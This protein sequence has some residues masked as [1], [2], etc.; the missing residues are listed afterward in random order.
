M[1]SLDEL[2]RTYVLDKHISTSWHNYIPIYTQLFEPIRNMPLH[3][4]EIGIGVV[5]HG[6]MI[7]TK[8]QGYKTGNSLRCWRDYFPYGNVYGVDIHP[9]CMSHEPRIRTFVADQSDH[10]QLQNVMREIGRPLDI[11]IDD[12]SHQLAHQV[13]SFTF[14]SRHMRSQGIYIIED[15]QRVHQDEF[16]DLTVF[17][18]DFRSYVQSTFHVRSYETGHKS[19]M[20]DD[21]M[22][23][24]I[25]K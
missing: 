19:P 22:M 25:K 3:I 23:V 24:F 9:V 1:T 8:D 16:K 17:P 12:G 21:F 20:D 7:H 5:E 14:L 11:I 18:E 6:Q 2:S 10:N 15:I 4:L 13:A